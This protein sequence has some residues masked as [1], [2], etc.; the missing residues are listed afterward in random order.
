MKKI[1][2]NLI[3]TFVAIFLMLP[4]FAQASYQD[5]ETSSGNSIG[6]SSLDF[7][8]DSTGDFSPNAILLGETAER[9]VEVKKDGL[10]DFKYQISADNLSG[11][12]CPHLLLTAKLDTVEKYSGTLV[13]FV[14]EYGGTFSDPDNWNFE[15]TFAPTALENETCNFDFIFEGWQENMSGPG[16]GFSDTETIANTISSGDWTID[17]PV[18]TGYNEDN[19]DD[20]AVP[21]DPSANEIACMGGVTN[22]NGISVHWTEMTHSSGTVKYQRQ[23]KVG[24]SSW[25]GNEIYSDPYTNYRT[26]GGGT[27]NEGVYGSRVRAWVDTN[28]NNNV[29]SGEIVSDWSNECYITYDKSTPTI[30]IG[31][32]VLNEFVPRPE[33]GEKEWVEI[34]N[35]T[36]HTIDV[37][38]W[39]ITDEL[40]PAQHKRFIDGS[41]TN[42]GGTIVSAG[43]WL[44]IE[45][46]N[47]FYLNDEGDTVKLYDNSVVPVIMDSYTYGDTSVFDEGKSFARFPDGTGPWIDPEGTPGEENEL[48]GDEL[49]QYQLAVATACFK[50][51]ELIKNSKESICNPLFVEYL[52]LIKNTNSRKL[53]LKGELKKYFKNIEE[54]EAEK[55]EQEKEKKKEVKKEKGEEDPKI[56]ETK[57]NQVDKGIEVENNQTTEKA[58]KDE[59]DEQDEKD[60]VENSEDIIGEKALEE[61]IVGEEDIEKEVKDVDE[62]KEVIKIE[63]TG[64]EKVIKEEDDTEK[65]LALE[66][67]KQEKKEMEE[68]LAKQKKENEEKLMKEKEKKEMEEKIKKEKKEQEEKKKKEADKKIKKKT[69][70]NDDEIAGLDNKDDDK[71]SDS[72]KKDNKDDDKS[73]NKKA[74]DSIIPASG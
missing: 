1:A 30:E 27:G 68:K 46:Y 41:H 4:I 60:A 26:F 5:T 21:H 47:S 51:G 61:I 58:E 42:T 45:N 48:K 31:D 37:A 18:Q 15:I 19:G 57:I 2:K 11:D 67:E 65:D 63:P 56:Q 9:D 20:Y 73:G 12:L 52:G 66:K 7:S 74:T 55:I 10:M 72:D 16:E 49:F 59:K 13:G 14:D 8:L 62:K 40:G 64:T 71:D 32:V 34:Y 36:N 50:K 35:N 22:I 25:A 53:V 33:T 3:T 39:F 70:K 38:D 44:V 69:N 28:G 23:Y 17:A 6:A 24:S 54:K 29:D 43:S